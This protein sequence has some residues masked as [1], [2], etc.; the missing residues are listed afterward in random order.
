MSKCKRSSLHGRVL[1]CKYRIVQNQ[2]W[3]GKP[4][5][6]WQG[7]VSRKTRSTSLARN[8]QNFEN[9]GQ[10]TTIFT[11]KICQKWPKFGK[12]HQTPAL[13]HGVST[14]FTCQ[15]SIQLY[16]SSQL[17]TTTI[18]NDCDSSFAMFETRGELVFLESVK[19]ALA[20]SLPFA[21]EILPIPKVVRRPFVRVVLVQRIWNR[22]DTVVD[23]DTSLK[24]RLFPFYPMTM[25]E[26]VLRAST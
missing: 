14:F 16:C 24:S 8:R 3:R 23:A 9:Q 22:N 21:S 2:E 19:F 26:Y 20:F 25:A 15:P 13:T 5:A 10:V 7:A 1:P 12:I 11:P 4:M 6:W 18:P 17:S